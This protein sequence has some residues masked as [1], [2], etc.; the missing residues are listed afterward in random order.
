MRGS[1]LRFPSYGR[2][3]VPSRVG[4]A[5]PMTVEHTVAIER[6]F[7]DVLDE[8]AALRAERERYR[9]A[10]D[11]ADAALLDLIASAPLAM[12]HHSARLNVL[13]EAIE[14]GRAISPE[15]EEG[16]S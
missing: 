14:R 6:L 11:D 4:S 3:G 10:L 2:F 1:A 13:A 12:L 9:Q 16:T 7:R 8:L 15:R 5:A